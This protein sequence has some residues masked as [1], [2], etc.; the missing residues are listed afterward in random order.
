M[1][2]YPWVYGYFSNTVTTIVH[3]LSLRLGALA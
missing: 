2:S 1:D 3:A